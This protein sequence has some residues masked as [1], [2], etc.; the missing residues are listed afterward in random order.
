VEISREF[1]LNNRDSSVTHR[2]R[3]IRYGD[4]YQRTGDDTVD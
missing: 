1:F 4:R 2:N 3:S